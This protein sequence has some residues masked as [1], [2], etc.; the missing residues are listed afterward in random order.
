MQI[1]P[2]FADMHALR[3]KE[4]FHIVLWLV[5]DFAWIMDYKILGLSM[6]IPTVLLAIYLTWHSR[7]DKTEFAHNLA[8][9]FWIC[10]NVI[11]MFGEFYLN[12]TTRSIAQ[13]FFIAGMAVLGI[14]YIT[15]IPL[16]RD[17]R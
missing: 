14:H 8:V 17:L 12:D 15:K 3:K 9:M 6:A 2:I 16:L 13:P 5:K 7:A 4:N 10:A 1:S 11:W